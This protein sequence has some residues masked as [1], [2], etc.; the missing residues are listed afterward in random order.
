MLLATLNP[1]VSMAQAI[2][3]PFVSLIADEFVPKPN[4][5]EVDAVFRVP[6]KIFLHIEGKS[7]VDF[8]LSG[9]GEDVYERNHGFV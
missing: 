1:R 3:T 4:E 9:F 7:Y 8:H 2:V 5:H 6:L